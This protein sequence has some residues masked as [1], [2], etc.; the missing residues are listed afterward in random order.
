MD[1]H[2]AEHKISIYGD[3]IKNVERLSFKNV[4]KISSA[5]NLIAMGK[6]INLWLFLFHI[7]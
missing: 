5:S 4:Q 7:I 1:I 3:Q 2:V 6:K